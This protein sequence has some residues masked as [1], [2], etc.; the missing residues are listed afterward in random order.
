MLRPTHILC[1]SEG[2][3]RGTWNARWISTFPAQWW[4]TGH[5]V[6]GWVG[7]LGPPPRAWLTW[8]RLGQDQRHGGGLGRHPGPG[9][10]G[11]GLDRTSDMVEVGPPPRALLTWRRLGPPPRALL[12]W[13]R[14][15]PP[16]RAWLTWWRFG[17]P[18]RALLTWRRLG[19]DQRHGEG[20][21]HHPGPGWHGGGLDRTS[22]MVEAWATTPGLADMEEA[23]TTTPDTEKAWAT[24]PGLADTEEAWTG[25]ATW[26]R[27]G[28]PPRAWLTRRRLGQDQRHGGGLGHHPG[29]CWHGGGLDRTSD[30]VKV[31]ATTPGLADMEEAWTGPA[32]WWRFGPPPRALLTWR[33]L[34]QDQRHGEGLGHHPGPG[35]HGGGLDRTSD[36]VEGLG[37][38]PRPGW[39]GGGLDRTSDTVEA[40]ATTPGLADMGCYVGVARVD[41]DLK[42]TISVGFPIYTLL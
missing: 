36:M 16:P 13:R 23:W 38:H 41:E 39:H 31:W 33:R 21:G 29:P 12:T 17:P 40:W 34:G 7:R 4:W 35:W 14:L 2:V 11:G 30:M 10:Q 32:T 15:G 20:L 8:R 25:P 27:L 19:Q 9:W 6:G 18:P 5:Q 37:H 28:P 1:I 24:T 3:E 26:W 42:D 22:D